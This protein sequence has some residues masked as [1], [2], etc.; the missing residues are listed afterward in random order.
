MTW[1]EHYLKD[2][3]VAGKNMTIADFT[4]VASLSTMVDSGYDISKFPVATAYLEKCKTKM[5]DYEEA[6]GK[7]SAQFGEFAKSKMGSF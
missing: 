7:G 2:G 3:F 4:V 5:V 6:N 1:L